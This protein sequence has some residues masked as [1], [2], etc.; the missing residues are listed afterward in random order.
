MSDVSSVTSAATTTATTTSSSSSIDEDKTAFLKLLMTQLE[1]QNPLDP[2][3]TTEFTNQLVMYSQL[4]Q[5]MTMN[6]KLD[7]L[8]E[9]QSAA[10]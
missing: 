7:T 2:V 10:A 9:A 8:I 5:M 4:E 3:D 6:S 1:N